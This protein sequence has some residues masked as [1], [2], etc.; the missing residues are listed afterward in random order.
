MSHGVQRKLS[1]A[2]FAV[3]EPIPVADPA[4]EASSSSRN[5]PDATADDG[6]LRLEIEVHDAETAAELRE[7]PAGRARQAFAEQALRIGVLA[8][9]HARGRID[10][11]LIRRES[12]AMLDAMRERMEEHARGVNDRLTAS[13]RDYFDPEHGSFQQ[14][15][16]ALVRQDGDLE[17]LMRRQIDGEDSQL[18]KTLAAHVGQQSPLFRMLSPEE[19]GGVLEAMRGTLDAELQK[20]RE[21]VLKE[22]SLDNKDG[23]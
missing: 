6:P 19:S 1:I 8:L 16:T 22:F 21:R 20:Q 5:A 18:V 7:H 23:A 13:L 2:D 11:D 14:R 9:R 15:I 4:R 17:Q 3:E 12:Q 10:A